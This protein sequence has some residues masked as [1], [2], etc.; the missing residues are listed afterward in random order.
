MVPKPAYVVNSDFEEYKEGWTTDSAAALNRLL[1]RAEVYVDLIGATRPIAVP[2]T[3]TLHRLSITGN[4]LELLTGSFTLSLVQGGITYTSGPIAVN[5]NHIAVGQA[6]AA[7]SGFPGSFGTT[8]G[9]LPWTP[10]YIYYTGGLY[11]RYVPVGSVTPTLSGDNSA[12]VSFALSAAGGVPGRRFSFVGMLY[13]EIQAIKN[14][15]CAQ[16]DYMFT[17]NEDLFVKAQYQ[18]IKGPDFTTEGRLPVVSPQARRELAVSGLVTGTAR[19][20]P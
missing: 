20:R 19:S 14:S 17:N 18:S 10:V 13:S 3:C 5:A 8:G 1:G 7:M 12:V 4:Q 9:P 15:V 2:G 16:A 11:G 6:L